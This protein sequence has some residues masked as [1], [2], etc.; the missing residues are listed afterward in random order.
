MKVFLCEAN[1]PV[2]AS[3]FEPLGLCTI[4]AFLKSKGCQTVIF[5]QFSQ[6]DNAVIDRIIKW[7][8]DVVGFSCID[9]NFPGA[10]N[11][12]GGVKERMPG[13]KVVFGGEHSTANPGL[14][15]NPPVDFVVMGEGEITIAELVDGFK[16]KI[17]DFSHI[18]GLAYLENNEVRVTRTRDR[19]KD[20][21]LLPLPDRDILGKAQYLYYGLTPADLKIPSSRLRVSTSYL[22]RGCAHNCSF[23]TTPNVWGRRWIARP[24]DD[25]MD[26]IEILLKNGI[27]FIYF[28]DENFLTSLDIVKEFCEK[29]IAKGFD[30]PFSIISRVSHI[31]K[32]IVDLLYKAG[33]RHVGVGI[34][35][36]RKQTLKKIHKGLDLAKAK[37]KISFLKKRGI[38]VCGLFMIGYP[39]E[40]KEMI[41]EY[42]PLFKEMGLDSIKI[43]FLTPFAGTDLFFKAKEEGRIL[44]ENPLDH[45]TE[46]P[47]LKS[48]HLSPA[49]LV[50]LRNKLYRRFYLSPGFMFR[51]L[52]QS[53]KTP[54]LIPGYF[55]RLYWFLRRLLK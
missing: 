50:S 55:A 9:V 23:C 19:I 51:I 28:Q 48:S 7:A 20:L 30:V 52:A 44:S 38:S 24:V 26:E 40:T 47:M 21:S 6:P 45:S 32:E 41:N 33:L 18:N 10:L 14:V 29:K 16:K 35:S 37:K 2:K 12:A 5:Q 3:R 8:P 27:N 46:S 36:A 43:Q 15:K 22:S 1:I 49:E 13:V 25:V 53:I 31:D 34:E 4:S 39:W 42:S 17:E 54:S 11:I